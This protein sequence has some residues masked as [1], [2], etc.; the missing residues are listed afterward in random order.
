MT[1]QAQTSTP[2]RTADA[3]VT[4]FATGKNLGFHYNPSTA[5]WG[6]MAMPQIEGTLVAVTSRIPGDGET[7]L[8]FVD[9]VQPEGGLY[10][11]LV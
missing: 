7:A 4:L 9:Q 5:S 6:T 11:D 1:S 2:S 10:R 3:A 8:W